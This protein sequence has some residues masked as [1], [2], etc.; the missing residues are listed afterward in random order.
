MVTSHKDCTQDT[1]SVF[2]LS[3]FLIISY[4]ANLRS[5]PTYLQST[6]SYWLTT[7]LS[8]RLL[9]ISSSF[10]HSAVSLRQT[11]TFQDSL[12]MP[13]ISVNLYNPTLF[14]QLCALLSGQLCQH[15]RRIS[16]HRRSDQ[17]RIPHY[18]PYPTSLF[19]IPKPGVPILLFTYCM[20]FLVE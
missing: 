12:V 7:F 10:V 5:P 8:K 4:C 19:P 18:T 17:N 16:D 2:S 14:V 13:R 20:L 15:P 3:I 1:Q 11:T 6:I 9:L